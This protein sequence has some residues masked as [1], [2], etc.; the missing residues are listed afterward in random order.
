MEQLVDQVV[1]VSM[2][3]WGDVPLTLL[4]KISEVVVLPHVGGCWWGCLEL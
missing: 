3:T 4:L 1:V 2:E